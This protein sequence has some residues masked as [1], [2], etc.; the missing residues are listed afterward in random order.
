MSD[1]TTKSQNTSYDPENI[2]AK[3]LNGDIP[4]HKI[5]QNDKTLAFMD[6][7]PQVAGHCL[8][9]P[10]APSRNL[11]DIKPTDLCAVM[12][13][14]QKIAIAVK[15]VFDADGVMLQQFNE[16]ASGQT[17]FHTHVHILP[18]HEGIAC[19]P[20]NADHMADHDIL[21]RHAEQITAKL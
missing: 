3:I 17:V 18:R 4:C 15:A 1:L 12:A 2:F 20:H 11:L 21:A 5:Y 7:M 16:A 13:T 10:K 19:K 9:I 8:V 6:V 14:V